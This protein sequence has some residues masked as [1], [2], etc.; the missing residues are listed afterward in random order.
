MSHQVL[1]QAKGDVERFCR[2]THGLNVT[3]EV[4]GNT[5][6]FQIP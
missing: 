5:A 4:F 3:S 1:I 2:I 6:Y